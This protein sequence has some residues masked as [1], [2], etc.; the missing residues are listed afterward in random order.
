MSARVA[1]R[2]CEAADLAPFEAGLRA[3]EHAV[4]YPLD[5]SG[6][7][8]YV[9]HG[10]A[11]ARFFSA[12]GHARFF[13]AER[14]GAPVGLIAGVWKP[15][16]VD[17]RERGALYLGDLKLAREERGLGLG[18]RLMGAGLWQCAR[19]GH[20]GGV[21]FIFAAAMRDG[22]K[23][24]RA[25]F[26]GAHVGRVG[27]AYATLDVYFAPADLLVAL[28]GDGPT[29]LPG[30]AELSPR[31]APQ[32]VSTA[33]QKDL[34]LVSTGAPWPLAHLPRGPAEWG[35]GLGDY[36][37]RG[38]SEAT[39]T[40]PG[41]LCCFA[42]DARLADQRAWLAARGV[43]PGASAAVVGLATPLLSRALARAPWL[44]LATSEI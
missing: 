21:R 4:T 44:H 14:A 29:V 43:T 18:A 10:A 5:A 9:D 23:D 24:V 38:A 12:M 20:L 41:A 40:Q 27:R 31:G 15:V 28:D 3:V 1:F 34:R 2:Y 37:R 22:G 19:R 13:V 42:L 39:T 32:V 11:Y 6:E 30:G 7:R 17:G 16:R 26:K 35:R 8:F 25:S 36:L 33:G